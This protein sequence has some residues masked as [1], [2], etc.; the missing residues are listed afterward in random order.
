MMLKYAP[1]RMS[2]DHQYYK[3]RMY[4]AGMDHNMHLFRN[5]A[6]S[7]KGDKLYVRKYSKRSKKWRPQPLKEAKTYPHIRPLLASIVNRR[8]NHTEKVRKF[9]PQVNHPKQ[10]SQTLGG[11][12]PATKDLVKEHISRM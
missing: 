10:I 2:F 12:P 7:S 5:Y 3:D 8:I 6:C 4:L 9:A 11:I 1:K